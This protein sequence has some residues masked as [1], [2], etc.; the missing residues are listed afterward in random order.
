MKEFIAIVLHIITSDNLIVINGSKASR[1]ATSMF[2]E[3]IASKIRPLAA[4][5]RNSIH[6]QWETI[7]P[8]AAQIKPMLQPKYVWYRFWRFANEEEEKLYAFKNAIVASQQE[9]KTPSFCKPMRDALQNKLKEQHLLYNLKCLHDPERKQKLI[10]NYRTKLLNQNNKESLHLQ[11]KYNQALAQWSQSSWTHTKIFYG[12]K[13]MSA[14]KQL[15][16]I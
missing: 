1:I 16:K 8:Y 3:T 6:K 11:Q 13:L 9:E 10:E 5:T 2:H 15:K 14:E 7:E 4:S 12:Y